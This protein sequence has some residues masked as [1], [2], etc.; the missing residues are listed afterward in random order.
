MFLRDSYEFLGD[1]Y[2]FLRDFEGF[3]LDR[4]TFKINK[5]DLNLIPANL[6]FIL[7]QLRLLT[8]FIPVAQGL[9]GDPCT[10]LTIQSLNFPKP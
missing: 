9:S 7:R 6:I 10:S 4:D 1:S 3:L 2:G 5:V 8:S